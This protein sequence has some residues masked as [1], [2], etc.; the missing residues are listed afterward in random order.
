[1]Q[2][3]KFWLAAVDREVRRLGGGLYRQRWPTG[4][5]ARFTQ[6]K[7]LDMSSNW[8][9]KTE[10]VQILLDTP[11]LQELLNVVNSSFLDTLVGLQSP[12]HLQ[13]VRVQNMG[14]VLVFEV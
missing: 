12:A 6:L 9:H 2:V 5:T 7:S 1:L 10:I 13:K 8:R 11:H 3:S 14:I 4:V